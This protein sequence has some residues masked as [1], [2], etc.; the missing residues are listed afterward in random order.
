MTEP[1]PMQIFERMRDR[2]LDMLKLAFL[3]SGR[4]PVDDETMALFKTV[5]GIGVAAASEFFGQHPEYLAVA[6]K[7]ICEVCREP[8]QHAQVGIDP[9][10]PDSPTTTSMVKVV[11]PCGHV[12]PRVDW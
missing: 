9:A 4:G 3:E 5:L 1:T 12:Q 2:S 10:A 7:P 11:W 6:H 8:V